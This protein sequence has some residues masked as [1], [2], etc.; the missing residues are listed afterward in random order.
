MSVVV[1]MVKIHPV[2]GVADVSYYIFGGD[3]L[4]FPVGHADA[5]WGVD[6]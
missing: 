2:V 3:T 4:V 1:K 6:G 5:S